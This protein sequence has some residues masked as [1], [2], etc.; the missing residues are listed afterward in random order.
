[1]KPAT[2]E[3]LKQRFAVLPVEDA[4]FSGDCI[5]IPGEELD[6][7]WIL[8]LLEEDYRFEGTRLD[9]NPVVLVQLRP[10]EIDNSRWKGRR[11]IVEVS[12]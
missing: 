10:V 8:L 3:G 2:I 7:D 1:V 4:G 9:G 11:L 5:I 6:L 12:S